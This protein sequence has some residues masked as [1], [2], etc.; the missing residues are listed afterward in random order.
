M[1]ERAS[2]SHLSPRGAA[3]LIGLILLAYLPAWPGGFLIEDWPLLR[4]HRRWTLGQTVAFEL[5]QPLRDRAWVERERPDFFTNGSWRP[6]QWILLHAEQR[7]FD[8]RT[9]GYF[10]VRLGWMCL[11]ALLAAAVVVTWTGQRTLAWLF[12]AFFA[13]HPSRYFPFFVMVHS[14]ILLAAIGAMLA[15]WGIGVWRAGRHR[16]GPAATVCGAVLAC[17]TYEQAVAL[18]LAWPVF[19]ALWPLPDGTRPPPR[20][21]GRRAA[22][23]AAVVGLYLVLR[24]IRM[25]GFG[26]YTMP[27]GE[28]VF[29]LR[30]PLTL[31]GAGAWAAASALWSVAMPVSVNDWATAPTGAARIIAWG[32]NVVICL[33]TLGLCAVRGHGHVRA[34][35][36]GALGVLAFVAW[37]TLPVAGLMGGHS[38]WVRYLYFPGCA[39]AFVLAWAVVPQRPGLRA[40][41]PAIVALCVALASAWW[42]GTLWRQA[43]RQAHGLHAAIGE[44]LPAEGMA[45]VYLKDFPEWLGARNL[46]IRSLAGPMDVGHDPERVRVWPHRWPTPV[47]NPIPVRTTWPFARPPFVRFGQWDAASRLLTLA[48]PSKYVPGRP[49]DILT[50]DLR[51]H[52][53]RRAWTP[54]AFTT[55]ARGAGAGLHVQLESP[56]A[57][58]EGPPLA[59]LAWTPAVLGLN[60]TV[61]NNGK[62]PDWLEVLFFTPAQRAASPTHILRSS[63]IADGQPHHYVISLLD[64]PAPALDGPVQRIAIRPS[65]HAGA[66]V[67]LRE[68]WLAAAAAGSPAPEASANPPQ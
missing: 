53:G 36:R 50:W 55:K 15:L 59:G 63:T 38:P 56:F 18:L 57:M 16:L 31:V 23:I 51:T 22:G 6:W 30:H 39:W 43:W 25:Q 12:G 27:G 20:A 48:R 34:S 8:D 19:D 52:A 14:Q 2:P 49:N 3:A 1:S 42:A 26:G 35:V 10:A 5:G 44:S 17:G 37:S 67:L 41:A 32:L 9:G 47:G 7:L 24:V 61:W 29:D 28:R 46:F 60:M 66:R 4:Q 11:G 40:R 64:H 68:V 45:Y 13:L 21:V 62:G 58:I 54:S 33:A 65:R